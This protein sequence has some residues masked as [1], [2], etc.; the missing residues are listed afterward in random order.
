M[1]EVHG[2]E[3]G[4]VPHVKPEREKSIKLPTDKRLPIPKPRFGQGRARIRRKV[5]IVLPPQPPALKV[6]QSLPE[7]M[8][9][10]QETVQAKHKSPTQTDIKQPTGPRI[11]NRPNPFYPDLT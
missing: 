8:T 11:E 4:L 9:Q 10:S 5:R 3:K 1:P 2:I 7:T 6:T